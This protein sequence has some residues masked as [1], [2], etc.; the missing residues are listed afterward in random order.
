MLLKQEGGYM[1][2][3]DLSSRECNGHV[4]VALRGELDIVDAAGVAAALAA[5][6]ARE[7][8][9][10]VDLA[11]L[12]FIDSSGVAALARGR[13]QA[14]RAGGDLLLAAL[15]QQVVRILTLTRL[16]DGF[17]VHTSVEEA[18]R[19]AESSRQ[20]AVP[21]LKRRDS[22]MR[23]PRRPSVASQGSGARQPARAGRTGGSVTPARSR[24]AALIPVLDGG[25]PLPAAC[26][27]D[28]TG[29][30]RGVPS[31]GCAGGR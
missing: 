18:I 29:S 12:E 17:T 24:A 30:C 7:P 5:V 14:R 8:G 21:V 9:I 23:W 3:V 19:I 22:K 31:A 4:V 13:R 10:I 2:S 11:G 15:R 27:T 28:E 26:N 6:V 16:V 20:V 25:A 1:F